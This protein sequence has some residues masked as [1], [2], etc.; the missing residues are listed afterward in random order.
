MK[1]VR[2]RTGRRP[3]LRWTLP[4]VCAAGVFYLLTAQG[5]RAPSVAGSV[6]GEAITQAYTAPAQE[7]HLLSLG[8]YDGEAEARVEAARYVG[9][10]TAGYIYPAQQLFVI[11]AGYS[12]RADAERV[13]EQ[14]EAAEGLACQVIS[15]RSE[16]VSLRITAASSQIE[17]LI[18]ADATLRQVHAQLQPL[19]FALDGGEADYLQVVGQ[20]QDTID[21]AKLA[22]DGLR[23][24]YE[25]SS[26][27][28][29]QG[30]LRLLDGYAESLRQVL[31][32]GADTVLAFSSRLKY[33]LIDSRL[34]YID[35]LSQ[36]GRWAVPTPTSYRRS[37]VPTAACCRAI[38]HEPFGHRLE[39][40]GSW[41]SENCGVVTHNCRRRAG[42]EHLQGTGARPWR[43]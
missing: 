20:L 40:Q 39:P 23:G 15:I 30:Y 28:L 31:V 42:K 10:G 34:A 5:R 21:Q 17:A 29:G 22:A 37:A 33:A 9:R 2:I 3:S 1:R 35:F 4:L 36:A 41:Y 13:A 6:G 8:G 18:T 43:S 38:E 24:D 16:P 14:L 32:T 25:L 12:T 7:I 26:L 19:A 11:A 27:P